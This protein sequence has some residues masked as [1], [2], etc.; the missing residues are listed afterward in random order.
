VTN[1]W[2]KYPVFV[3]IYFGDEVECRISLG[4]ETMAKAKSF[5]NRYKGSEADKPLREFVYEE[6]RV[7]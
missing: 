6:M 1:N 7:V 3:K 2:D 4:F 5:E